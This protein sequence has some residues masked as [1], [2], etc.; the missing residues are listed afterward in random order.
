[1]DI[2]S[3]PNQY[4]YELQT[5]SPAEAKRLWRRKIKEKWEYQCAYCGA[6]TNLTIDHVVPRAK[7][8]ADFTNNV[9]CCCAPCNQDK[10]HKSWEEWYF[11]QDFFSEKRYE[12]I[13]DWMEPDPPNDLFSYRPRRNNAS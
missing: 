3:T 10:G 2:L 1:M 5:T 4:L 6:S 12:K 9:V 8:G 11:S 7:G 13:K